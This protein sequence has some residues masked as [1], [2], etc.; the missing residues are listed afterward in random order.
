MSLFTATVDDFICRL[1]GKHSSPWI[2]TWSYC[3]SNEVAG[4]QTF[5]IFMHFQNLISRFQSHLVVEWNEPKNT[6]TQRTPLIEIRSLNLAP[7]GSF[8]TQKSN[9]ELSN[10]CSSVKITSLT[11]AKLHHNRTPNLRKSRTLRFFSQNRT[12]NCRILEN[13]EPKDA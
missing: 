1:I 9:I 6:D 12:S 2:H 11:K 4:Y 5:D 10:I 3:H 7:L 8:I 13:K